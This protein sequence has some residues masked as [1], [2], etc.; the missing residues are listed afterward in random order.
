MN[1]SQNQVLPIRG[2]GRESDGWRQYLRVALEGRVDVPPL[3]QASAAI[4]ALAA[5]GEANTTVLAG[6]IE[7]DPTVAAHVLRVANSAALAP[8]VPIVTVPQAIAWL[9]MGEIQAIA[10]SVAVRSR[11]FAGGPFDALL[12]PMWRRAVATAYWAR[13]IARPSHMLVDLAHLCGLLCRIG[14]PVVVRCLAHA[15]DG[16]AAQ[17]DD[18]QSLALVDEFE[19]AAGAALCR[20]WSLPEPVSTAICTWRQDLTGSGWERQLRQV[21]LADLLAARTL[22]EITDPLHDMHIESA[23]EALQLHAADVQGL[24]SSETVVRQA[25]DLLQ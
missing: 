2:T 11:L 23:I 3:S 9:G 15:P 8:R 5:D 20:V 10:T 17:L 19:A 21:R 24:Q 14:R 7:R 13:E 18:A 6:M 12:R 4:A 16:A 22:D 25:L 1:R